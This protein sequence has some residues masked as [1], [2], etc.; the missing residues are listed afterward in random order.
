MKIRFKNFIT[1][2]LCLFLAFPAFAQVQNDFYISA[3]DILNAVPR[4]PEVK[5]TRKTLKEI[6]IMER[7][8]FSKIN[9]YDSNKHRLAKLEEYLLGRTWEFLPIELRMQKLKLASQRKVLAGT[10]LPAS[11]RKFGFTPKRI[12][13]DSTPKIDHGDDVGLID[14]FLRLKAPEA[15]ETYTKHKDKMYERYEYE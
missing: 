5:F 1:A 11:F 8:H 13:N 6:N 14:G 4:T 12:A 15:Y 9:N 7:R 10:A 3:E 2:T